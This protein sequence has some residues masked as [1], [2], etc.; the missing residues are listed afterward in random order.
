MEIYLFISLVFI[1]VITAFMVKPQIVNRIWTLAFIAAF[2][3]TS[4]SLAFLRITNQ[5]VMMAADNLN[6]YY[7]LYLFG[8]ISVILGV[9]NMWMYRKPLWHVIRSADTKDE[10]KE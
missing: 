4:V 2:L 8:S 10:I 5:D 7:L 1:Y 3:I 6:W 9:I